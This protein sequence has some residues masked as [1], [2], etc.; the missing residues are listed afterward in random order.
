MAKKTGITRDQYKSIKRMDHKQM[1]KFMVDLYTEGFSD[2]KEAAGNR[3][4]KASDIAVAIMD[5]KGVGT[6]K[7]AEIMAAINKL[8][9]G[10]R[11]EP[12]E[13]KKAV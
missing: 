7:A 8:Y 3:K 2:G 13:E 9:E 12:E 10:G 5:V 4:I 11:N 6:K 1:E